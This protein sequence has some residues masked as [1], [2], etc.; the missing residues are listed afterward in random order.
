M[1]K[2]FKMKYTNG[3]KAD[4]SSFPFKKQDSPLDFNT[5]AAGE[6]ALKGASM[7]A[8]LGP[9]GAVA[10]GV[11]GGVAAGWETDAVKVEQNNEKRNEE[12]EEKF[13]KQHPGVT[14]GGSGDDER[15]VV[16]SYGAGGDPLNPDKKPAQV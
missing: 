5:E 15:K 3:K 6:G 9:W 10:G 2:P 7:G 8:A 14:L 11:I 16:G 1:G 4:T 13:S 12:R